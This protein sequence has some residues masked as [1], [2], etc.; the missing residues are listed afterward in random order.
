M[1]SI[2]VCI[3]VTWINKIHFTNSH[4]NIYAEEEINIYL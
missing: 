4:Y 2:T 3:P 1:K